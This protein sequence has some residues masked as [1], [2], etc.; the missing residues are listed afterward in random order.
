MKDAVAIAVLVIGVA[1]L[2]AA[3][4]EWQ[5][6]NQRDAGFLAGLGAVVIGCSATIRLCF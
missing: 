2:Y 6:E 5:E 1:I 3:T 4:R